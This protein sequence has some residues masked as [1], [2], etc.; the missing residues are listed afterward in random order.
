MKSIVT[1]FRAYQLGSP[2]SFFTYFAGGHL[3]I[4]E[5]RLTELSQV[6]LQQ[7]MRICEKRSADTLHITSWDRDHCHCE[8]LDPLLVLTQPREIEYPGYEPDTANGREAL[9]IIQSYK[10][11]RERSQKSVRMTRV[12]P[13]YIGGLQSASRLAFNSIFYNPTFIDP[14]CKND[15]STAKFFRS[16]SFNVLSLGDIESPNISSRLRRSRVLRRETDVMILPHHG[17]N[18]GCTTKKFLSHIDPRMAVCSSNF[19]NQYDHPDQEIR[20]LL[21]EQDIRLMTTKTGDVIIKS[22]GAHSGD[23]MA[24]NLR[25]DSTEISSKQAFRSKKAKLLS[26]NEDTLRQL[27]T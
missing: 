25:A 27:Y 22:I 6:S 5:G 13:E 1:R 8:E 4:I 10:R 3:T 14:Y 2:G 17:A 26:Y 20:D 15:N 12:T 9:Q 23:Y 11:A 7:E 19:G 18:N 21:F 16:G 24:I